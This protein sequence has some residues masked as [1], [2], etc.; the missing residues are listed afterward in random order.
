MPQKQW[1]ENQKNNYN[2][3]LYI[4]LENNLR[5]DKK[6]V[7]KIIRDKRKPKGMMAIVIRNQDADLFTNENERQRMMG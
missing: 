5:A 2:I 4:E 6:H 1:L 7:Y 3:L